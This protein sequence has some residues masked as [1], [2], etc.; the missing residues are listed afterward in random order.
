MKL[1]VF[2]FAFFISA[3][4]ISFAQVANPVND[5]QVCDDASDGDDT[6][7]F[8][9]G[10]DFS[11]QT[12]II[13]GSQSPSDF[14][15]TYHESQDDADSGNNALVT[16]PYTNTV[17]DTQPIFARVTDNNSG[18][19]ATTSFNIVVNALPIVMNQV[20]LSLCDDDT[21]G[22]SVFDLTEANSNIS[23]NFA[24]EDFEFYQTQADAQNR[25]NE[26]QNPQNYTN[27]TS[28]NDTVWAR[29]TNDDGCFRISQVNLSVS[30]PSS[31]VTNF[32]PR[33]FSEC[34]DFLD[35][36]GNDTVNNDNTDGISSF[37]IDITAELLNLFPVNESPHIQITYYRT[38]ID[39][40]SE[41]NPI[42]NVS[43]YRNIGSPSSQIIYVRVDNLQ[44]NDCIGV[45]P[46]ITLTVDPVPVAN[47]V[48]DLQLED[49]DDDGDATNGFVQTFDLSSQTASILGSQN[50]SDFTVSYYT[51]EMD[52]FSGSN[53]IDTSNPYTNTTPNSQ[54][55]YVRVENNS[56]GCFTSGTTFNL[57]VTEPSLSTESENE[58]RFSLFPNPV[59]QEVVI[60]I[61]NTSEDVYHIQL[62]DI[63]GKI[64]QQEVQ[65]PVENKLRIN[66]SQVSNGIYLVK[67]QSKG[68]SRIKKL[69]VNHS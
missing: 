43:N 14:T 5:I 9:Q 22:F 69:I 60:E 10:F 56:T 41:T 53:A 67:V 35:I 2:F 42:S 51:S 32:P 28:T 33:T 36:D 19:F 50:P 6:N 11:F 61:P 54:I 68:K 31:Q 59:D 52:A 40:L 64:I 37:N 26:I 46:I 49:N 39:A 18:D 13:L 34:D 15:V 17:A 27:I 48:A 16:L 62:L 65:Q 63:Q 20:E 24:N 1:R 8:F 4:S 29:I 66:I 57:V 45:A 21:D 7:G 55:I 25:T 44:N 12:P 47:P 38:Q 3:I 58:L 30:T 23:A